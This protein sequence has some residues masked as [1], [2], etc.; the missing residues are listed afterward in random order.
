MDCRLIGGIL[1]E[2][3]ENNKT[4]RND[5]F[6]AIP[7]PSQMFANVNSIKDLPKDVIEQLQNFFINYNE[8]AGKIFKPLKNVSAN[9][10]YKIISTA[11]V[12]IL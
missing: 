3:T 4:V 5:R 12:N 6:L 9:E 11:K 7:E 10:A 8:A 1:A 2:Q